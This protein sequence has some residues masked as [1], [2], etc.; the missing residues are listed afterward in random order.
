MEIIYKNISYGEIDRRLFN[1]FQRRQEVVNCWRREGGEWV[2]K[3]D[4][5]TDDWSEED[6]RGLIHGLKAALE[7]GGM[8][9][10]AF[11]DGKLKGFVAVEGSPMGSRKQYLDLTELHVSREY[12]RRGIGKKLFGFAV[13]FAKRAGAEKLYISA[14]SAAE[15]QAFYRSLGCKDAEE[16]SAAHVAKEPYDCQ[17]EFSVCG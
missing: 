17:L 13:A 16:Y 3:P 1:G 4:P 10:G 14:H 11:I 7:G 5:F 8:V 9:R 6:Y 15:S 12:R 2:I